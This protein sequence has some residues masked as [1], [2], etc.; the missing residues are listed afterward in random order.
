M[1]ICPY[2]QAQNRDDTPVCYHCGRELYANS[3]AAGPSPTQPVRPRSPQPGAP[4]TPPLAP[5]SATQTWIGRRPA[6]LPDPFE[7]DNENPR[8]FEPT[9]EDD[10]PSYDRPTYEES[11]FE[12]PVPTGYHR[13]TWP[14]LIIGL[15]LMI[16]I[17]C[18]LAG[19]LLANVPSLGGSGLV[20][21]VFG[22]AST[23]GPAPVVVPQV[24]ATP[25]RPAQASATPAAKATATANATQ[26][27]QTNK[28]LSTQCQGALNQLSAVSDQ[29]KNDPLKVLDDAWRKS[30]DEATTNMK[31]YCGSLDTAS[32]IPGEIGQV[33]KNLS[34]ANSEFDQAKLL[35][36]QAID[37]KDPGKAV[38]AAQHVGQATQYL[39]QAITLLHNL[40]P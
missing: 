36:N 33:Q 35:W 7:P 28:L 23:T 11:A 4:R 26:K 13:P 24:T 25:N 15:T 39:G 27:A 3:S 12:P 9:Y 1:K 29:A 30:F 38:S 14:F 20:S 40:V 21:Q 18:G 17:G 34:Q 22:G 32:P 2:C 37:Q 31:T 19:L 6:D 10:Q 16:I 5:P 8:R